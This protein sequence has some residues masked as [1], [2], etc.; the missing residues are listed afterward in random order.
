M[1]A[2]NLQRLAHDLLQPPTLADSV[3]AVLNGYPSTTAQLASIIGRR[4]TH[5]VAAIRALANAGQIERG[6]IDAGYA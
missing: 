6:V 5:V 1:L 2:R 3:L 4:K